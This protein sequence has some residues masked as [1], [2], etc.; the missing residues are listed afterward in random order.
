MYITLKTKKETELTNNGQDV[1]SVFC[2]GG[3]CVGGCWD[4]ITLSA[5]DRDTTGVQADNV[6]LCSNTAE[7]LRNTA[8]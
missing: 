5:K 7:S 3:F 2:I 8:A 6:E 1:G 4:V